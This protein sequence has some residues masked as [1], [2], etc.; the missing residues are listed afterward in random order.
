MT[1]D[2]ST[3]H[4]GPGVGVYFRNTIT[5]LRFYQSADRHGIERS[6]ATVV[7]QRPMQVVVVDVDGTPVLIHA[8]RLRPQYRELLGR[9]T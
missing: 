8:M 3:T 6:A 1:R 5:P 7:A 4:T 2:P 9:P